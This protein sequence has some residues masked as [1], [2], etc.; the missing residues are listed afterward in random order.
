MSED[1]SKDIKTID[2]SS[3]KKPTKFTVK[4]MNTF[5]KV[6]EEIEVSEEVY[7]EYYRGIWRIAKNNAKHR[8]YSTPF[9]SVTG[10]S[11]EP[12]DAFN[13]F[14]DESHDLSEFV[15]EKIWL[16]EIFAF[17]K[18]EDTA[19]IAALMINGMTERYYELVSGINRSTVHFRK[20]NV[21]EKLKNYFK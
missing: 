18:P 17:F 1:T 5:T 7:N 2:V 3:E 4:V 6:Q 12:F 16:E 13:D 14:A 20:K 11:D 9:S 10:T 19:L 21:T 8:Y 15:V